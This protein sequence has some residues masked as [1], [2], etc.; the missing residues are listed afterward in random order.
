MKEKDMEHTLESNLC[1]TLNKKEQMGS[2]NDEKDEKEEECSTRSNNTSFNNVKYTK[3]KEKK[4]LVKFLDDLKTKLDSQENEEKTFDDIYDDYLDSE[5]ITKSHIKKKLNKCYLIFMIFIFGPIFGSI[6]LIGIFQIKSIM[7]ALFDLITESCMKYY[8]CIFNSICTINYS[9][10]ELNVFDFYNYY[11]NYTMNESIDANLML[12]TGIIGNLFFSWIGFGFSLLIFGLINVGAIIW[13]LNFDFAIG[14]EFDYDWVKILNL[15]VIYI[16]FYIGL[17]S[18]SLLSQQI[19][20]ESYFKYKNDYLIEKMNAKLKQYG[21]KKDK[22]E[23]EMKDMKLMS[24][25]SPDNKEYT[26]DNR[27]SLKNR[28]DSLPL[29]A[30]FMKRYKR[31]ENEIYK[32]EKNKF[33]FFIMICLTTT[34][35]YLGKLLMNLVLDSI[36]SHIYGDNYEK[37]IFLIVIMFLY[38]FCM[39]ISTI[40]YYIYERSTFSLDEK[41]K[42]KKKDIKICQMCGFILYCETQKLKEPEKENCCFFNKSEKSKVVVKSNYQSNNDE[43]ENNPN[44]NCCYS[45]C[46][47]TKGCCILFCES[48]QNCCY[49]TFG[50]LLSIL[51]SICNSC[52][53][54]SMHICKSCKSNDID[55]KKNKECFCYCYK[56]R[57]KSLWCNKFFTNMTVKNIFP[58]MIVYFIL[59]LITIGFEKQYEKYKYLNF[60]IKT[61]ISVSV[62]TFIL[63]LYLT[64]S[65]SRLFR[66]EKKEVNSASD[67]NINSNNDL[68]YSLTL[69]QPGKVILH[70]FKDKLSELSNDILNGTIGI[71]FFNGVFSFIFSLF[72]FVDISEEFKSFFFKDNINL[73]I[74]PIL[75]NNFYYLTLNYYCTYTAEKT[76]R[77][78]ILSCSTLIAFYIIIWR[79][80]IILIKSFIPE[81]N[82]NNSYINF[83]ILYI[84]QLIISGIITLFAV[85]FIFSGIIMSTGLINGCSFCF[86]KKGESNCTDFHLCLFFLCSFIFCFG[87]LW[88]QMIDLSNYYFNCCNCDDYCTIGGACCFIDCFNDANDEIGCHCCFC[89]NKDDEKGDE[90]CYC[91]ICQCC[92]YKFDK[93]SK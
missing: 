60:H 50:Y 77:F 73:I 74:I 67:G 5:Y 17:G 32:K 3:I 69:K 59:Q 44:N 14:N 66:K 31:L 70:S 22:Y 81:E 42:E 51:L 49:E 54:Q 16:I 43:N 26:L 93:I 57:R 41:T 92:A 58:F 37:R 4:V 48:I 30:N 34:F 83:Q 88:N 62:G 10:K 87:G 47:Y 79:F 61:F 7:N 55:Y 19:L 2:I 36:L 23:T 84:I 53:S 52:N 75:M 89:Q 29:Y 35:G 71:L 76:K 90:C 13:V 72:Y 8:Y 21:E 1:E 33:D 46:E 63:F 82:E 85:C 20:I 56:A 24:A 28:I 6:Y 25:P 18:S 64:L 39:V 68:N 91:Q 15:I 9:D 65:F 45:C 78:E 12:M 86:F 40:L 38:G 27:L 80:V 11:Y